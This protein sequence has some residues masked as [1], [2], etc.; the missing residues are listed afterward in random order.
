MFGDKSPRTTRISTYAIAS[1]VSMVMFVVGLIFYVGESFHYRYDLKHS[2]TPIGQALQFNRSKSSLAVKGL[3]T[4]AKKDVLIAQISTNG[5][6]DLPYKGSDYKILIQS[7]STNGMYELPILFGRMSTD[8]DMFFI[9]PNPTDAVYSIFILNTNYIGTKDIVNST[10]TDNG[11]ELD[12]RSITE[13]ISN[14]DLKDNG[15]SGT[16]TITS[17]ENDV[18]SMRLTLKPAFK[19]NAYQPAIIDANLLIDKGDTQ[20]FDFETLFNTLYRDPT[21]KSQKAKYAR[22]SKE[23]AQLKKALSV[24]EERY[25]ANNEDTVAESKI[26]SIN[27]QVSNKED[28]LKNISRKLAKYQ[29]LKYDPNM[30]KDMLTKASVADK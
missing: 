13:A 18:A 6:S 4:D 20:E 22:A 8:G 3:Y 7:E 17:N 27:E 26:T 10:S 24:Q 29:S 11:S 1:A 14:Y 2:S 5:A 21:I 9:L 19:T 30:F 23:L 12:T 16:Y 15:A 25:N 28:E